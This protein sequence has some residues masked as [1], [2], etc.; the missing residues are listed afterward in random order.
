MGKCIAH[1]ESCDTQHAI[2]NTP[3]GIC[4]TEYA[5]RDTE[6]AIR[7]TPYATSTARY[8]LY[9]GHTLLIFCN[10]AKVAHTLQY[11]RLSFVVYALACPRPAR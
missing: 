3:Y 8:P 7:N 6:Y 2:R 9:V 11:V 5:I 4:D 10:T 1:S